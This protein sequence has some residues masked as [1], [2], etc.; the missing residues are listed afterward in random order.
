MRMYW[1]GNSVVIDGRV[2]A[3]NDSDVQARLR[4]G[5]E[6]VPEDVANMTETVR[7][8]RNALLS[9]SDWALL[10][11]AATDKKAWKAYRQSLRDIPK[12]LGFP[13][14]VQWPQKPG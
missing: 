10:P 11:D 7:Q 8:K 5:E 14:I 2:T 6:I 4:A 3:L 9:E 1:R 12:Q 13:N